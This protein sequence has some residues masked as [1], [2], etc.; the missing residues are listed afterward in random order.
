MLG[1]V[2]LRRRAGGALLQRHPHFELRASRRARDAGRRLDDLYPRHRVP[3][4]MEELDLDRHADGSTRRSSPTRTTR[5][6]RSSPRCASAACGSSTSR[7]DFR[8]RDRATYEHWYG[9][10]GAPELFGGAV[11][12]L[13]ELYREEIRDADLVA[14]PGCFPTAALLGL[15]PLARAGLIDD[16]VIDAKTGVSGAGRARPTTTHFVAVDENVVAYKVGGH[17]HAPGDRPGAGG[18]RRRRH[19][20]VRAAPRAARPGRADL[21]LRHAHARGRAGRAARR[22]S[23]TPTRTSRSSSWPSAR[24]ACA[25]C[26]TRTSA[27]SPSTATATTAASRLRGDRQPL[28]GHLVAGGAEP[29]PDVRPR[30]GRGDRADDAGFFD[31]RWV[32]AARRTCTSWTGGLPA[33]FRAAGVAAG[34]KRDGAL[35]FGLLVS[36]APETTSAARFTRS[37]VVAAPVQLCRERCDL[38]HLRAVAANAGNANA[39]TGVPGLE[40]AGATQVAASRL[41]RRRPGRG[42]RSARPA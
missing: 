42:S 22:C 12:G 29:Q 30:R 27:A 8:L 5:P 15:A 33:G 32:A 6:R 35:D 1:A 11:Y 38:A 4:T 2:R 18:A 7:A 21:L 41:T 3:L 25:T 17:R 26:A 39:A 28:E 36:D 40:S 23:R 24:P 34:L 14:N 13:P 16:V 9:P 20:H 10:H 19:R 31:S 37:G